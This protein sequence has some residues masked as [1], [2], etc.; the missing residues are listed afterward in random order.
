MTRTI[1]LLRLDK[2]YKLTELGKVISTRQV[3]MRQLVMPPELRRGIVLKCHAQKQF[4]AKPRLD[5]K[6]ALITRTLFSVSIATSSRL[7]L[8]FFLQH[9]NQRCKLPSA[10]TTRLT[11]VGLTFTNLPKSTRRRA[12]QC[13][14]PLGTHRSPAYIALRLRL[15]HIG[16]F[17]PI[18]VNQGR[19]DQGRAGNK[20]RLVAT[21]P[22]NLTQIW[23]TKLEHSLFSR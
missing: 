21:N 10:E 20:S 1:I 16:G 6:I 8:I 4:V 5:C 22:G 17:Q 13:L 3:L 15:V 19:V 12:S 9:R 23:V 18:W 2:K 14:W 7:E 11:I